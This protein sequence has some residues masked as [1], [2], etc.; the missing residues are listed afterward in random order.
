MGIIVF[1]FGVV[2]GV[3]LHIVYLNQDEFK[4]IFKVEKNNG[5]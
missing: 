1:L 5:K 2:T 3:G 4:I